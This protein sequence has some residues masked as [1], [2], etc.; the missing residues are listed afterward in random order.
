MKCLYQHD[1]RS[2]SYGRIGGIILKK[3]AENALNLRRNTLANSV[4]RSHNIQA[5]CDWLFAREK[6]IQH[7]NE[8]VKQAKTEDERLELE[9]KVKDV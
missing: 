9:K 7:L 4:L 8:L 2:I 6:R 1:I 5:M 3:T